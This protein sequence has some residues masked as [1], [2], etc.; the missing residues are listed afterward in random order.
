[1][2]LKWGASKYFRALDEGAE[3]G[4]GTELCVCLYPYRTVNKRDSS[5]DMPADPDS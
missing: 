3:A 5:E 4:R 1:M 2:I